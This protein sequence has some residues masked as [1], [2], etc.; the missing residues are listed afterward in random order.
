MGVRAKKDVEGDIADIFQKIEG[1]Q[2]LTARELLQHYTKPKPD[3]QDLP[4]PEEIKEL[5]PND[6]N[7]FSDGSVH[8]PT[9]LHW[10]VGGIGFF[11]PSRPQGDIC[12]AESKYFVQQSK[13]KKMASSFGTSL[14]T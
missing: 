7:A 12:E 9:S 6:P 11:W 3:G 10:Q 8:N 4:M 5:A 1:R 2:H 14:P 13:Y